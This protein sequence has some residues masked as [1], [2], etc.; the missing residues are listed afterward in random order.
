LQKMVPLDDRLRNVPFWRP[1][2][3]PREH[4]R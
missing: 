2:P 3:L 4:S 1:K